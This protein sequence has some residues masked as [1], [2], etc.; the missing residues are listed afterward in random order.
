MGL[1]LR[2]KETLADLFREVVDI[3]MSEVLNRVVPPKV[4][5][6]KK[7][8]LKSKKDLGHSLG[9]LSYRMRSGNIVF[10]SLE[11]I[12]ERGNT[13]E[14]YDNIE[15]KKR[16]ETLKQY[17]CDFDKGCIGID[18]MFGESW[19]RGKVGI[20]NYVWLKVYSQTLESIYDSLE[21]SKTMKAFSK[22]IANEYGNAV[23]HTIFDKYQRFFIMLWRMNVYYSKSNPKKRRLNSLIQ[24]FYKSMN[25][26]SKNLG[27]NFR[28]VN[29]DNSNADVLENFFKSLLN[30][31]KQDEGALRDKNEISNCFAEDF[32]KILWHGKFSELQQFIIVC[33]EVDSAIQFLKQ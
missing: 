24:K 21:S 31:I 6:I 15:E 29:F 16:H 23:W 12:L 10:E 33:S 22:Q 7:M 20:R 30:E 1:I 26:A 14:L 19:I 28:R 17:D 8:A 11:E 4:W 5:H 27:K 25:K 2:S 32:G 9:G 3:A 13:D 18:E